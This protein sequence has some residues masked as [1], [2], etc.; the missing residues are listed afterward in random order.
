MTYDIPTIGDLELIDHQECIALASYC[1]R[2]T[3]HLTKETMSQGKLGK[4]LD[5]AESYAARPFR[6]DSGTRLGDRHTAP[7][8]WMEAKNSILTIEESTGILSPAERAV[9]H[10]VRAV[11]HAADADEVPWLSGNSVPFD[12]EEETIDKALGKMRAE[13]EQAYAAAMDALATSRFRGH[14]TDKD[15]RA[16]TKHFSTES[17]RRAYRLLI[18][19]GLGGPTPPHFFSVYTDSTAPVLKAL[20]R[21][22][23]ELAT[24]IAR[25]PD[26][27]DQLEWR[28]L[29]RMLAHVFERLGFDVELT[30]A[31]KD[32]G[33]DLLL[34]CEM[35][36]TDK[37]YLVEVKHW[38]EK[39]VGRSDIRHLVRVCAE[40]RRAVGVF[41][42]S[43][44]YLGSALEVLSEV[45]SMDIKLG[46]RATVVGLCR[47]YTRAESGLWSRVT[48]LPEL[49][50][51]KV[52]WVA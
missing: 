16:T 42:T 29:E 37:T 44:G 11:S 6:R 7:A 9:V 32:G 33:R 24:L 10:L 17:A 19:H 4:A 5:L 49:V 28:D 34:T 36:M 31:A 21:F 43:Y 26:A 3:R 2:L 22:S 48:T 25:D 45:D 38:R 20:R 13:A 35:G 18:E 12:M 52:E 51:D 40:E 1:T 27:L 15:H 30:R 47:T 39:R 14:G 23:D 41:L 50:F 8:G 46:D